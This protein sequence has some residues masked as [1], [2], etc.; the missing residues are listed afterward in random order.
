M[1]VATALQMMAKPSVSP[2]AARSVLLQRK[3]DCGS[4]KS[5]SGESCDECKG[6]ALQRK[7]MI[8]ASNDPLEHEADRAADQVTAQPARRA[9]GT[10][11]LQLQRVGQD[12]AGEG[13]TAPASVHRALSTPGQSLEPTLRGDMDARFGH[14]FSRVRV[15]TDSAADMSARAVAATAYTVGQDIAFAAGHFAPSTPGGLHLIAHELAHTIQQRGAVPAVVRRQALSPPQA[16][17]TEYPFELDPL[18]FMKSM[19]APAV[20]EQEKCEEM[21][22]GSTDCVVDEVTGI[23]TGKV[24]RSVDDTNP[25]TRPCVEKHEAVHVPQMQKLC[26]E[27]RD[28]YHAADKGK[29]PASDCAEMSFHS[30]KR[31]C[32]A[33]KVSVRC[34]ESRLSKAKECRSPENQAYGRRKLASEK[35]FRDKNCEKPKPKPGAPAKPKRGAK[36]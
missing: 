24:T 31:E 34:V 25:C 11:P 5:P 18:M 16:S 33:Y 15:H 6:R 9:F 10:I 21:P 13:A 32:D 2:S 28:C 26:S 7:L 35:C 12:A 3:C 27:V 1:S 17:P 22:G 20:P 23:P 19:N 14:D 8:G 4:P 29:R 30:E 36:V